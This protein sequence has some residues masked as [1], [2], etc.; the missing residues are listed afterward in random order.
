MGATWLPRPKTDIA[1]GYARFASLPG[2]FAVA[3]FGLLHVLI[4]LEEDKCLHDIGRFHY[5]FH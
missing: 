5:C 1:K 4:V 3:W 2:W